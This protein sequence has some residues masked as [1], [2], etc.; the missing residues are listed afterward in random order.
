MLHG[1]PALGSGMVVVYWSQGQVLP[2]PPAAG[3]PSLAVRRDRLV[4]AY[5]VEGGLYVAEWSGGRWHPGTRDERVSGVCEAAIA[6]AGSLVRGLVVDA[7]GGLWAWE[8]PGAPARIGAADPRARP[9]IAGDGGAVA[10]KGPGGGLWFAPWGRPPGPIAGAVTDAGPAVI[11]GQ[12]GWLCAFRSPGGRR[13]EPGWRIGQ[14][15][16]VTELTEEGWS[17]PLVVGG[18][19]GGGPALA[20]LGGAIVGAWIDPGGTLRWA[21]LLGE[22]W[23]LGERIAGSRA[24]AGPALTQF[25]GRLVCAWAEGDGRVLCCAGEIAGR[26]ASER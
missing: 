14:A 18:A 20:R 12:D 24:H 16:A 9:A 7:E 10:F 19:I 21:P 4:C 13:G 8:G 6:A 5:P 25:R 26:S 22:P 2:G 17:T 15:L 23:A 3:V 1:A 11:A